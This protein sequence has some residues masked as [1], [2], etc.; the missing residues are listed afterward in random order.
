M[1]IDLG[2][3]GGAILSC[4]AVTLGLLLLLFVMSWIRGRRVAKQLHEIEQRRVNKNG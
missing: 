2:K 1:M 3:Y 4:Y